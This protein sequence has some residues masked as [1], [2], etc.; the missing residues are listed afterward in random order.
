MEEL[1]QLSDE[2]LAKKYEETL[3]K[4][5][6]NRTR[7][8]QVQEILAG[9]TENEDAVL[10]K[11][12]EMQAKLDAL[13]EEN[14]ALK[15]ITSTPSQ[16][17]KTGLIIQQPE[18]E[19]ILTEDQRIAIQKHEFAKKKRDQLAGV[20]EKK[21]ASSEKGEDYLLLE[22]EQNHIHVLLTNN[23]YQANINKMNTQIKVEKIW[24]RVWPTLKRSILAQNESV[25]ILHIPE[26]ARQL[27]E[28]KAE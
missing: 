12:E 20:K 1:T 2:E 16:E 14:N 19:K 23:H 3:G 24:P 13:E 27:F 28:D 8:T 22:S 26:E 11:M 21:I 25:E 9:T 5:P 10:R 17:A 6:G 18:Y 15:S 7:E 4:K